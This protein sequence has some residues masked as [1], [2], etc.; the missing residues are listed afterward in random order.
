MTVAENSVGSGNGT[1]SRPSWKFWQR[2][3][4]K[5]QPPAPT[6]QPTPQAQTVNGHYTIVTTQDNTSLTRVEYELKHWVKGRLRLMIP[7]LA[8]DPEYGER[9]Q[10]RISA[11]SS[12]FRVR[13]NP[14]SRSL[15]IEYDPND[16]AA[17]DVLEHITICIEDAAHASTEIVGPA[18]ATQDE[19]EFEINYARRL[20]LPASVLRWPWAAWWG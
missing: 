9:L 3:P 11:T 8:H 6:T 4:A 12:G 1:A 17:A 5:K 14:G 7:R 13:V 16:H 2:E 18:P 15:V 19:E 10:Y 20:A